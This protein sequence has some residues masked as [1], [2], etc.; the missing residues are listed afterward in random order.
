M[1]KSIIMV[2]LLLAG[3]C[4]CAAFLMWNSELTTDVVVWHLASPQ[5]WLP[6]VPIGFLPV[7]GTMIGAVVMAVAAWAPWAAQRATARAANAKLARAIEK[8]N[9]LKQRLAARDR[10]IEELEAQVL[11]LQEQIAAEASVAVPAQTATAPVAMDVD[12]EDEEDIIV[13]DPLEL[14]ADTDEGRQGV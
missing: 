5:Y 14:D 12:D 1:V 2:A 7:V 13:P 11:L 9:E 8:F 6:D 10:M 3:F 4:Y